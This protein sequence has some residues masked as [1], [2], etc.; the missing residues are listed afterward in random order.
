MLTL[1][2]SMTFQLAERE[3]LLT[4]A[5]K[6]NIRILVSAPSVHVHF[7]SQSESVDVAP[8]LP[9]AAIEESVRADVLPRYNLCPDNWGSTIAIPVHYFIVVVLLHLYAGTRGVLSGFFIIRVVL[10]H[11]VNHDLK[12]EVVFYMIYSHTH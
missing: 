1:T 2:A 5:L 6:E 7:T 8:S 11:H 3:D 9:R 4:A 10:L 12:M